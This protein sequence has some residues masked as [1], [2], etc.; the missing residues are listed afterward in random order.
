MFLIKIE[1]MKIFHFYVPLTYAK[2]VLSNAQ[3][4]GVLAN[5]AFI[6]VEHYEA[7]IR[8]KRWQLH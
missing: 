4:Y 5:T 6:Y 2:Y 3:L 7:C 8:D 1:N